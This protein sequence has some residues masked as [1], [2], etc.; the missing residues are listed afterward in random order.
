M[1]TGDVG[2]IVLGGAA[3]VG[4]GAAVVGAAVVVDGDWPRTA[5]V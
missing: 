4:T 5:A 2:A 1:A 3:E